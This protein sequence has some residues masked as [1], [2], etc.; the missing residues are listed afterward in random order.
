VKLLDGIRNLFQKALSMMSVASQT[1]V[2]LWGGTVRE[3]FAGAWQRNITADSQ[4]SIL[5]FSAVFA[6]VTGIAADIGKMRIK[7]S[8]N[9]DGIWEEITDSH[10]NSN[11][12]AWLAVLRKPNHYQT[13]IKFIEHWIISKLLYGA[14]YVWKERDS[15][16]NVRALYVLDPQRVTVLVATDGSVWYQLSA[17]PLSQVNEQITIPASEIIHDTMICLWHP[18]IGVSPIYACAMSATMGNK[19]QANST[20]LFANLSRP[21]GVVMF[22]TAIDD[23]QAANF[24]RRWEENFGGGNMGRTAI[25][26]NGSK[27]EP[28]AIPAEA[29]QL[30]EQ[31]RWTVEDV[32]R[33]FHYP[34]FKLGGPMPTYNSIDAL[35]TMYYTD[36]LQS[37]IESLE[38][39]LD[40]GLSLPENIG[41]EMD[42]DG[43]MRMD[44]KGLYEAITAAGDWMKLDEQRYRANLPALS[45]GGNTVY[46]Q[47]QDFSIEALAKRDASED[48]FAS[49]KTAP[50]PATPPLP[51]AKDYRPQ[52]LTAQ[53][54]ASYEDDLLREVLEVGA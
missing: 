48:P 32:A 45:V 16:R 4:P 53:E 24:K 6:C 11:E 31:L 12:A 17:D 18:L 33:A 2:S 41:T 20:N 46:K 30:I 50:A 42:L 21:G 8:E 40:E 51:A 14:A 49:A 37:L 15:N 28:I 27:F 23:D 34:A 7:L 22:P 26:D 1:R 44:T 19:I 13:R 39:C 36:C 5:A 52:R 10:G 47:Q 25:L 35:I 43:L 9:N 29:A 54:L 3:P 38:L